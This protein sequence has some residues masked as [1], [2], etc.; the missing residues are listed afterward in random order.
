MGQADAGIEWARYHILGE[1]TSGALATI[2]IARYADPEGASEFRVIKRLHASLNDSPQVLEAVRNET[3]RAALLRHQHIARIYGFG[4]LGSRS[5]IVME[6]VDGRPLLDVRAACELRGRQIPRLL[7]LQITRNLCQ[8]LDHAHHFTDPVSN[9]D[10]ILHQG[11]SLENVMVTYA[12]E[13][14]LTNF[15]MARIGLNDTFVGRLE[16][17][18]TCPAPELI[19]GTQVDPR[20]DIFAVGVVLYEML[21]GRMPWSAETYTRLLR[22]ILASPPLRPTSMAPDLLPELEQILLRALQQQRELRYQTI[23][24]LQ[25]DLE[26]QISHPAPRGIR[27]RRRTR[28]SRSSWANSS[29]FTA[30]LCARPSVRWR[31]SRAGP[32]SPRRTPRRISSRMSTPG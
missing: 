32:P 26:R 21:L 2:H 1:L 22:R 5:A 13:V 29:R 25:Q 24:E 16:Q 23:A 3:R 31:R 18:R 17:R 30:T 9:Q 28:P 12:G 6:F 11:V 14:K 10:W 20:L 19:Q 4:A 27:R 8:A 7:A 15:G